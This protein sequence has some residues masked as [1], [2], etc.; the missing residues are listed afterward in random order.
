[1]RN[2]VAGR[3]TRSL[4]KKMMAAVGLLLVVSA[5]AA[6]AAQGDTTIEGSMPTNIAGPVGITVAAI[7]M[8]GLLLG[9]WRFLRK[10]AKD[11]VAARLETPSTRTPAPARVP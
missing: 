8:V 4:V 10:S 7:G 6:A 9:L 5:R 1:V 3:R 11:R 2:R